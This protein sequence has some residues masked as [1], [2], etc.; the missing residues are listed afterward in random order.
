MSHFL[1]QIYEIAD[2][3]TILRNGRL[4]EER[5]VADTTQLELV[6]LMIGRDLEVLER[7]GSG[8]PPTTRDA[9]RASR[10]LKAVGLQPQ[11]LPR[12]HRTSDPVRRRGASASPACSAPGRTELA[13][14]LFGADT[15][16]NGALEITVRAPQGCAAR[17]HAIDRKV[18]FSSEDRKAE[19]VIADLTVRRQH[20]ARRCRPPRG[21]L[22]PIPPS[23]P[24]TRLVDGVHRRPS[25][26]ARPTRTR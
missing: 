17:G 9:E 3:M 11:G 16:D 25:T 21:W 4:V 23:P 14:L 13:R 15:A 1:D 6:K 19:G 5:M 10:C 20:A 12:G 26:S 24:A 18:A 8:P 2:R 7:L 22:R